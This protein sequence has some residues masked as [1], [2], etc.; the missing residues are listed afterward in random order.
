MRSELRALAGLEV[1]GKINQVEVLYE[2]RPGDEKAVT[3]L[4]GYRGWVWLQSEG[5][6]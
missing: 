3:H 1:E 6:C 2:Q 4:R 5:E